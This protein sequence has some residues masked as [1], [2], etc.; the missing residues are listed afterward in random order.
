MTIAGFSAYMDHVG[1]SYAL[2][3]VFEKPLKA[4]KSCKG[5]F[6]KNM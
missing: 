2:F 1:A 5:Y 3:K 6:K 4:V